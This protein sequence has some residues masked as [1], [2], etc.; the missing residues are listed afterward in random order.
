MLDHG[1]RLTPT[2]GLPLV[3]R[4]E[5]SISCNFISNNLSKLG[6]ATKTLLLPVAFFIKSVIACFIAK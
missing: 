6:R 1:L 5:A 3:A 2:P 4:M